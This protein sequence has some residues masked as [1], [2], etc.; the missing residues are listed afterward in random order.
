M[1]EM[2]IKIQFISCVTLLTYL[3]GRSVNGTLVGTVSKYIKGPLFPTVA[4]HS[5]NEEY[6]FY[7]LLC[8]DSAACM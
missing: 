8:F 2:E 3:I 5:R 7:S 1:F 4:V 6:C